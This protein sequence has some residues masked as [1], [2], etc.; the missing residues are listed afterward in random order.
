CRTCRVRRKKCD[1]QREGD[2]C[3]TCRRLTIK[4]L[5]WGAKRPD[6][7]R[8]KKNVDAYKASIKAQLSRAG[9]I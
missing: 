6:W 3:K 9:L 2:S 7:M 1:E 4:C 8:D 5:G